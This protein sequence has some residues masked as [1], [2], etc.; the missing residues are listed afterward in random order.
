[1]NTA[2]NGTKIQ[3]DIYIL[4][5]NGN[6]AD[7]GYEFFMTYAEAKKAYDEIEEV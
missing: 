1:M 5:A 7:E 2:L 3:E 6:L 4:K